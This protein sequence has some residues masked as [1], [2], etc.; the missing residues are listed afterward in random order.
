MPLSLPCGV[1]AP[2]LTFFHPDESLDLP[3]T[4][5]H[6]VRL[7]RAGLA[8]LV[9]MGSNGEA[10]HLSSAEKLSVLSA[11]RRALD[12]AGFAAV[13]VLFGASAGSVV[14]TVELCRKARQEG[15]CG[16]LVLPPS[17]YRGLMDAQAIAEYFTAVADEADFPIVVYNYP[18]AV[19]GID[20]DSDALVALS[21]HKNIVG[22]KFTCG[23]TG[24]LTRVADVLQAST[25][26]SAGSGFMAFGGMADFTVQ[27]MV[28]GGSGIIAGG[29][30][31]LPKLCVKVWDTYAA[32]DLAE[33]ARLQKI[34]SKADWVLTK[35]AI[36]GTKSAVQSYYG[37][38]A[39]LLRRP[40]RKLSKEQAE[41]VAQCIKEAMDLEL[42]L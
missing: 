28:G 6:A 26:G 38:G 31:V 14:Q 36:P 22:V 8:G 5:A 37:Y 27:T 18:G 33:A 3:T 13:P 42:S 29:A 17:Y 32:G 9:V 21:A 41:N 25:A 4:S 30:N 35:T 11:T 23:N 19:A 15:A 40:L 16:A 10:I 2:T 12:A 34:L 39:G 24:K 1:Y 7:A 20:L